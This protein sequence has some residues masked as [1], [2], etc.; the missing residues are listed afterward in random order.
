MLLWTDATQPW[1]PPAFSLGSCMTWVSSVLLALTPAGLLPRGAPSVCVHE[2]APWLLPGSGPCSLAPVPQ[3]TLS[4]APKPFQA[5]RLRDESNSF[6]W[7][8]LNSY[9]CTHY[10]FWGGG[11]KQ[12]SSN[13]L[14]KSPACRVS[15][16]PARLRAGQ[17]PHWLREHAGLPVH[18]PRRI[19]PLRCREI[20]GEVEKHLPITKR[21]PTVRFWMGCLNWK[22]QTPVLLFF[23]LVL[24]TCRV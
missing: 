3:E 19:G 2:V 6:L 16:I 12:G 24:Y 22:T 18:T 21:T 17:D 7:A 23:P 10:S 14:Q 13:V 15:L 4:W 1:V 8:I 5:A 9:F 20:G 11:G